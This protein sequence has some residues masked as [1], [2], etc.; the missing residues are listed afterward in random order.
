M[1]KLSFPKVA[2]QILKRESKPLSAKEILNK[3]LS[4]NM[5]TTSGKTPEATMW[6]SLYLDIQRNGTNSRFIQIGKDRFGLREWDASVL[7]EEIT[8]NIEHISTKVQLGFPKSIVGD[9]INF[10][11]LQYAPLNEQG[12]IFLF[13]KLH[14]DLGIILEAIQ[15]SYPDAKGRRKTPKSWKDVWIEFEYRSS[16]FKLHGHDPN[17]CDLIVC[18]EHDW[19]DCPLEV[20]ELRK[21]IEKRFENSRQFHL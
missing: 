15:V 19:E 12:V 21:V 16:A 18:W 14:K 13:G 2:Y 11:G 5:I 7:K 20:I 4:E 8:N 17:Q 3:A 1:K 9:P 10:E 6:S